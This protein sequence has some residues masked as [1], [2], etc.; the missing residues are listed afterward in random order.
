[1]RDFCYPF[2]AIVGQ[3]KAKR[4]LLLNLVDPSIGGVLLCGQ[5]GTAKSTIVRA[6]GQLCE[7]KLVELPLNATEDM[8]VG[9]V[10]F[11]R[12][13]EDGARAPRR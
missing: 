7:K 10:D 3:E 6:L 9:G 8:L 4:A 1:M 13:I 5:K 11:T 2:A 12:T